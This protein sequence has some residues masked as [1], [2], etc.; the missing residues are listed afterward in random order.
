MKK[1]LPRNEFLQD[2]QEK[3]YKKNEYQGKKEITSNHDSF[4]TV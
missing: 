4:V 2:K 1:R 3:Y